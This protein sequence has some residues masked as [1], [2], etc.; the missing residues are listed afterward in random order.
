MDGRCGHL[1]PSFP[2]KVDGLWAI[3]SEGVGLIVLAVSFQDFQPTV[4]DP[5][6]ATLQTDGRTTIP[7]FAL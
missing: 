3:K 5:D 1:L 6:P 7:R 4:C 2:H